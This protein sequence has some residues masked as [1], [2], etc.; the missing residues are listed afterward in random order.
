MSSYECTYAV[1]DITQQQ[2]MVADEETEE[3]FHH[4]ISV[5]K[6]IKD[7]KDHEEDEQVKEVYFKYDHEGILEDQINGEINEE[8]EDKYYWD[9]ETLTKEFP[10]EEVE[11]KNQQFP[12]CT[13]EQKEELENLLEDYKHMFAE[14]MNELGETDVYE[15]KIPTGDE[16]PRSQRLRRYSDKQNE[17]IKEEI[18]RMLEAGIIRP[19]SSNWSSNVVIVDKK[20]GKQ[21]LCVDYRSVNKVTKQDKYPLPNIQEAL[22][23]FNGAKWFTTIDLASGY[24]Q[25][26]VAEEDIEKTA[27]VTAHGFYEYRRMPFGLTNA[28]AA[29]QRL[30]DRVL[31]NEMG[32]FVQVY[33]DDI[34]VYS[35]SWEEHLEHIEQVFRRLE[36]AGLK[37]GRAKCFFAKKEIEFLTYNK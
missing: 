23:S 7:E 13:E 15:H 33:L 28:P 37:M 27:F 29:F 10:E 21:R 24:W 32:K 4:P 5:Y 34:I 11:D 25:M 8:I 35:K 12:N 31:K 9:E 2:V 17:F 18:Q 1:I 6:I 16:F 14:D 30:M 20:N 3:I 36:E 22:D 26:K 19:S